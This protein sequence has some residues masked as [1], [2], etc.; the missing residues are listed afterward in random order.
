MNEDSRSSP[1][2]RANAAQPTVDNPR[3]QAAIR[4]AITC[5]KL[6]SFSRS[7][8][9][10]ELRGYLAARAIGHRDEPQDPVN[11]SQCLAIALHYHAQTM[12]RKHPPKQR[13]AT[14]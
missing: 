8:F 10:R 7:R 14:S 5:G 6:P 2:S 1:S 9:K 3:T 11:E 4:F 13:G 12:G